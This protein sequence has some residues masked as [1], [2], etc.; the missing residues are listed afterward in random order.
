[1]VANEV[2][3]VYVCFHAHMQTCMQVCFS[4]GLVAYRSVERKVPLCRKKRSGSNGCCRLFRLFGCVLEVFLPNVSPVCVASIFRGQEPE[5]CLCSGVVCG[6]VIC[7]CGI[8]FLFFL[9]DWVV[10]VIRVFYVIGALLS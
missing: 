4:G 9:G 6:I 2:Y 3:S 8:R 1:M 7:S 5:L 10:P